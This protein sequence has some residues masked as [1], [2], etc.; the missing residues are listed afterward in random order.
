MKGTAAKL[1]SVLLVGSLA[2]TACSSKSGNEAST[3]PEASSSGSPVASATAEAP[4]A[5]N[6]TVYSSDPNASWNNMQD[7]VGKVLTEK[8]GVTLKMEFPV[9]GAA[10]D[11][12]IA[13]MISGGEYPDMILPKGDAAKLVDAGAL[14]DLRPLIEKYAPNIKKV[15]GEYLNRLKWSKDDDAIYI[16]PTAGVNQKY[17]DAGGGFQ[18]QHRVLKELG[19]PQMKTVQDYENAIKT[20]IAKHPTTDGKPTIGMSLNAGEWQI[21]ISTTNPAFYTTGGSDN[22]EFYI[23]D[24]TYEATYHY[25]RPEEKEYFRWLNHMNDIGLLD[26]ES[27]VQKYDQYKAKVATGRVL[28][29]I[30]Q[31]WD[32]QDAEKALRTEGKYDQTYARFPVTMSADIKQ[33]EFQDTGYV[34]GTGIGITVSGEKNAVQLI[35]FLDYL[36][37]DEGQVL[38]NWGVENVDYKV[39]N[40]KRVIL[41]D[42]QN[43]RINDN[44]NYTK[45]SGVG[46]YNFAP[47]YGDGVNDPSGNPY[48]LNFKSQIIATYTD[49]EKETLK[50]YNAETYLDLWPKP[51][52]FPVKAWGA[53]W[54]IPVETGSDLQILQKKME[55]IMKKRVPQAI[56]AKPADF[57]KV[58][59]EFMQDID[60]AGVKKMNELYTELVKARVDLWK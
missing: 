36:A 5:L 41:D 32:Y 34:A 19:Y 6:A 25:M 39:D 48:T 16:L 47:W 2:L 13:L 43:R 14:I 45:E 49:A 4:K 17:F 15:Y 35:K 52:E 9:G 1:T 31:Q 23:D 50:A 58:W 54:N 42:I 57:D 28:G 51:E 59:D 44:V 38:K 24:N 60:K 18:L 12:K 20:Y 40:G 46:N 8:T 3:S 27:F 22:G 26:K 10:T 53:A 7:R 30:D 37:S 55:D 29:I 33:K 21:L 56:L 11:Q